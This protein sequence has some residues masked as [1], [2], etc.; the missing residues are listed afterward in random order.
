MKSTPILPTISSPSDVQSLSID[1]L[2]TLA[3]EIHNRIVEVMAINGGHLASN[4]GVVELT[5]ALHKVFT[6]PKDI[7]L[8]DVSHQTYAHK[9]LTGRNYLFP[10]IRK[11]KGLSG[12][13]HPEESSHDHFYAGHA[14]TALSVALGMAKSRDLEK[15]DNYIITVLGDASLTCGHT[16]EALNNIDKELR[17]F[18]II[19]NDNAMSIAKNVGNVPG[20]LTRIIH[21]PLT[22]RICLLYTSP[23]PRD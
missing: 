7:F 6:S 5:L 23:S 2:Q 13:A 22:H 8:F 1:Q 21:N 16:L 18:I 12:F 3:G 20:I 14:G 11:F 4:L 10:T 15:R 19:L 9:I 17:K